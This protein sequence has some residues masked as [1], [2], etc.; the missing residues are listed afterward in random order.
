L[1]VVL[2]GLLLLGILGAIGVVGYF[3]LR[4]GGKKDSAATISPTPA[5]TVSPMSTPID[6][7]AAL[8]EKLANLEKQVQDQKNQKPA[9]TVDTASPPKPPP[10][11]TTTARVNSPG[12][13]F[14]A[15][16]N[17]PDSETGERL[18]K[19]PHGASVTVLGC[20]KPSNVGKKSGRWCQV[21]YN[22][23]AGWAFDAFL[24]F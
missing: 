3:A 20:P 16:R 6:E 13:G 18:A 10:V 2:G 8:K 21:I 14:L 4:D 7:T 24:V 19:I 15:L 12:D 17:Q 23:Q 22:G 1:I 11:N 9:S 5:Q